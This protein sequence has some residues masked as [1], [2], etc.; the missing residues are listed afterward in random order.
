MPFIDSTIERIGKEERIKGN[1]PVKEFG[2]CYIEALLFCSES[3]IPEPGEV[4]KHANRLLKE[5]YSREIKCG[6]EG[7]EMLKLLKYVGGDKNSYPYGFGG[8]AN[9]LIEKYAR[10]EEAAEIGKV[11]Y[12][13]EEN[14]PFEEERDIIE[15]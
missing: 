1:F 11:I 3:A 4:F 8:L 13:L 7:A 12:F 2:K 9:H 10:D 15:A 14:I 5:K 6:V